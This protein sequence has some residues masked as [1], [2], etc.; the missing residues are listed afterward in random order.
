MTR[1]R[2]RYRTFAGSRLPPRTL[3]LARNP[4][5]GKN[6]QRGCLR[7]CP[8][9]RRDTRR[10]LILAALI[11][12]KDGPPALSWCLV[13]VSDPFDD[14]IRISA[15]A[16]SRANLH[17]MAT[18]HP[19][20]ALRRA[21]STVRGLGRGQPTF[22]RELSSDQHSIPR[23][24]GSPARTG[25]ACAARNHCAL[26]TADTANGSRPVLNPHADSAESADEFRDLSAITVA[27]RTRTNEFREGPAFVKQQIMLVVVFA[28]NGI[29]TAAL[30]QNQE[31]QQGCMND[32]FRLCQDVIPDRERV[33]R[34]LESHK[35]VLS[36]ACYA[37]MAPSLPVEQPP[38]QKP[39]HEAK[40]TKSKAT[41]AR[42]GSK[43]GDRP[44]LKRKAPQSMSAK[45]K[46]IIV[47]RAANTPPGR[48]A[49]PLDLVPH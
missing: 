44:S 5:G 22:C 32:A 1:E 33:F 46:A 12:N 19:E 18:R 49:R 6:R 23:L 8:K 45:G 30:S 20:R 27:T 13:P 4:L 3:R 31:G 15:V 48:N 38:L 47:K 21:A 35:N 7:S 25:T 26:L 40:S 29:T 17:G 16:R 9:L 34:C 37:V 11:P 14:R 24:H 39:D 10:W 43:P 36:A 42:R 28:L 2:W 41:F